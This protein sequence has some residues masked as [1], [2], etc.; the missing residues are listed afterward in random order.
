MPTPMKTPAL[1]ARGAGILRYANR[2][3]IT[4][5]L[6]LAT[7]LATASS[8]AAQTIQGRILD[9][10]NEQ[11]VGGAIV[12]LVDRDGDERTRALADSAG[13]F[14]IAP[15]EAGEFYL[16]A[17]RFGYFETRSP[18]I[19][20]RTD[21]EAALD[22]MLV[23]EPIG[24]EGLEVSV[25]EL[26]RQELQQLGLTPAQL[27]NRW[28][29]RERIDALAVKLDVGAVLE[30]TAQANM[31]VIR[32]ENLTMGSDDLGLCV[33]LQQARTASGRGTCALVVLDGI[34]I[35]GVGALDID[36]EAIESIAI[37]EPIEASTFYGTA[38]GSGAVLV[39][40]RRGG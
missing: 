12:S 7:S 28:I 25:E 29:G 14:R 37:L 10:E 5:L 6:P 33:S 40:T 1:A 39:W 18:L 16:V 31:R 26:A 11:P 15:P 17:E 27:G 34:P 9:Q 20:L 38:G 22:L 23:P 32:P 36:P 8:S 19:A 4:V 35:T 3:S 13:R 24:I 30:R 21:G 2:L